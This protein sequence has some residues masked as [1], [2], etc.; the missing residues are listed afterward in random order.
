MVCPANAPAPSLAWHA[1]RA[2]AALL[3]AGSGL[4][5]Q[6]TVLPDSTGSIVGVVV[7]RDGGVPL[8][9]SVVAAPTLNRER[10]S[11]DQG[12]FSLTD[13]PSGPLVIRVRHIGYSPVE[14]T[15]NVHPG[16]LDS[17]RV[18]LTHI[19]VRLS[20]IEVHAYPECKEPGIPRATK[21]SSFALVFD[22]LRLNADQYRLLTET[23]PF[24]YAAERT[25]SRMFVNGDV[26]IDG[27]DTVVLDSRSTWRYHPGVVLSAGNGLP[28][29]RPVLLNIPTL[30]H[31]ADKSFLDNHCFMNGGSETV[32]GTDLL[33]I[34]FV[35]ASRIKDPD[36]NG[37]M[38]LDP[39]TFQI[40]RSVIRLSRIPRNFTNLRE[41]EATTWFTDALSSISMIAAISS[42]NHLNANQTRP[43]ATASM[44]EE[45][46]LIRVEFLR[47]R[48]GDDVKRP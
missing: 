2:A 19:V 3:V 31:F 22:Q 27:I 15:V 29:F 36:V 12:V 18:A 14:V 30:V 48:P 34:D 42:V 11:N 1:A 37:S 32:D 21:D 40:R 16:G 25:M 44:H 6:T 41:T 23:Y 24:R 39:S 28:G 4:W 26:R 10:F 43:A 47:T 17:I 8:P 20:T 7:V 46:R 5:A 45:Q 33:R 13:L 38:Y 35:A 9:Y